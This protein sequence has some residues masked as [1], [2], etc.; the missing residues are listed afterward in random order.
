MR[1]PADIDQ[2]MTGFESEL[3]RTLAAVNEYLASEKACQ[4]ADRGSDGAYSPAH[5]APR[6]SAAFLRDSLD[7]LAGYL[8]QGNMRAVTALDQLRPLLGGRGLDSAL[9]DLEVKMDRLDFN[10][11]TAVLKTIREAL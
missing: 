9:A 3:N 11:A 5:R 7:R 8:D 2:V 10:A 6:P 1:T 4:E